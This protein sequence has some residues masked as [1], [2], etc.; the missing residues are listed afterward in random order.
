MKRVEDFLDSMA[1]RS[2]WAKMSRGN[3][4]RAAAMNAAVVTAIIGLVIYVVDDAIFRSCLAF[5][6]V[7]GVGYLCG[8]AIAPERAPKTFMWALLIVICIGVAAWVV[9]LSL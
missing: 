8:L 9:I 1:A 6:W 4:A 7:L 2:P 3:R 5:M